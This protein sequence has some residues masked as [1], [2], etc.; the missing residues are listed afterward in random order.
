MVGSPGWPG[1]SIGD[2]P[3][4]IGPTCIRMSTMPECS[5]GTSFRSKTAMPYRNLQVDP[6]VFRMRWNRMQNVMD[7]AGCNSEYLQNVGAAVSAG[8]DLGLRARVGR[9]LDASLAASYADARYTETVLSESHVRVSS[10][11]AIGSLP[12]VPSPW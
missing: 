4:G 1:Y 8:F 10:G 11:D 3:T 2:R 12:L 9:H 6:A 7:I 5:R